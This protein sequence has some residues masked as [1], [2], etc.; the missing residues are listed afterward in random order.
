MS[1][2]HSGLLHKSTPFPTSIS[3]QSDLQNGSPNVA[4]EPPTNGERRNGDA[5]PI[6]P[7]DLMHES[8]LKAK[9]VLAASRP[10]A[11]A[12]SI[13]KVSSAGHEISGRR[14]GTPDGM[15][16]T[17]K[18]SRSGTRIPRPVEPPKTPDKARQSRLLRQYV[19]RELAHTAA[20][21]YD[22]L[23]GAT[24]LEEKIALESKYKEVMEQRL[25]SPAKTAAAL[26][27]YGYAG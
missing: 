2:P 1:S 23:E 18:R 3:E 16:Y 9:A 12:E 15:V 11:Y 19:A 17:R 13:V 6:K 10:L 8:K 21:S 14:E 26:F 5:N 27:G 7:A 20:I 24:L 4:L 22:C 25:K